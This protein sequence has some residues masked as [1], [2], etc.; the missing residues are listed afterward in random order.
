M[1]WQQRDFPDR[2]I[3]RKDYR[4]TLGIEAP[5]LRE[6]G[7]LYRV[8]FFGCVGNLSYLA[9]ISGQVSQST[10]VYQV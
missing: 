1:L 9:M 3:L 5:L 2:S 7:T 4:Q 6:V 10:C 8:L